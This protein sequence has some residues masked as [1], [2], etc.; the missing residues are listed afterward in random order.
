MAA[1]GDVWRW[2]SGSWRGRLRL[3]IGRPDMPGAVPQT[4]GRS[5]SMFRTSRVVAG[6]GVV[7]AAAVVWLALGLG[8]VFSASG[9]P[10]ATTTT[11]P[12][13]TTSPSTTTSPT[14]TT[15]PSATT[16]ST[17]PNL[18][19]F[20]APKGGVAVKVPPPPTEPTL[21]PT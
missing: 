7:V 18:Y 8:G 10:N 5:T 19:P 6:L 1:E 2:R 9:A 16:G 11:A 21:S 3:W 20:G 12:T 15:S 14:T 4:Y 17:D 13:T